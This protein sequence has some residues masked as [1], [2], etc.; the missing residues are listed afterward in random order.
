[1]LSEMVKE[2][3]CEQHEDNL[4]KTLENAESALFTEVDETLDSLYDQW[5][6]KLKYLI[7]RDV[8]FKD[9]FTK[10]Q[11]HG[12]VVDLD[13]GQEYDSFAVIN[14]IV[15]GV[16]GKKHEVRYFELI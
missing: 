12:I 16:D 14:L 5:N 15:R 6:E 11:F 4:K 8:S 9:S 3:L 7:G 1:M 10:K 13:V 2:A